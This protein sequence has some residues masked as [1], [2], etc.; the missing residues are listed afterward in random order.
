MTTEV[1]QFTVLTEE[2]RLS[3]NSLFKPKPNMNNVLRYEQ[4]MLFPKERGAQQFA[5]MK[6]CYDRTIATL[7][8]KYPTPRTFKESMIS[9]DTKKQSGRHGMILIRAH[10]NPEYPPRL[11][12]KNGQPAQDCVGPNGI[13]EGCWCKS[14]LNCFSWVHRDPKK[15]NTIVSQGA[16]FGILTVIKQRDDDPFRTVSLSE[17]EQNKLIQAALDTNAI[18][19]E[20]VEDLDDLL[21]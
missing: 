17:D 4:E 9:G 18:V 11:L 6:A 16:S 8:E 2:Y 15:N 14:L 12:L 19:N 20:A 1:Q 5:E 13:Y 3:F 7:T 10:S 21:G